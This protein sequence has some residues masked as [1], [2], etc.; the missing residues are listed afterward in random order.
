MRKILSTFI[1]ILT[2]GFFNNI[3]AQANCGAAVAIPLEV[4]GSC[5][6]M[7]FTNVDFTA[8]TTSTDAPA[9]TCGGFNTATE[10]MWYSFEVP[11]GVTELAFHAFNSPVPLPMVSPACAPGMAVYRGTCGNLTLIDC[12]N[13]DAGFMGISNGEIRWE[14]L[15]VTPGE[16][17]Y[18]RLWEKTNNETSIFFAAS[19]ITSLPEADCNNPPEL[20]TTGC[21]ILAPSGTIQAP[22]DCGW[23]TTDNVV[24]YSF[25]VLPTDPQPVVIEIE[26]GQCWGN[27][28]GGLLPSNP[29]IQF[30]V[31]SWNGVNCNGIGGG[32]TSD[33]A[34]TTTYYGCENGVGTVVYSNTLPP[35]QYVLAMDGHSLL[36]G[37]SLC[38]F[39][40]AASFLDEPPITGEL[41]VSLSKVNVGCG[42]LGSATITINSA[43]ST[44]PTINWSTSAT[45]TTVNNL[46]VGAYSVTVSDQAPCT[47]TIINFNIADQSNF[48]VAITTSGNP[49]TGPVTLL[50]NVMGANPANVDF[51]WSPGGQTTQSI[52]VNNGGTYTVTATYGTCVDDAS[53]TVTDGDFDFSVNY[54]PTFC[55]GSSG[56]AQF[57]LISGT[58]PFMYEWSTGAISPGIQITEPGNY[59]LTATDLNN[60]CSLTKC[61]NV[62]ELP[63]VDVSIVSKDIT[64]HNANDGEVTAI[65]SGGTSPYSYE[66]NGYIPGETMTNLGAGN[67]SV[68]VTDAAGCTGYATT[69]VNNPPQFT[70][71]ISPNQGICYGEQAEI[72]VIANG[73]VEPYTY[74]WSDEPTNNIDTRIVTPDT[75]T[76]YWVT[77]YDANNCM[78]PPQQTKVIVSLPR[79]ISVI[80]DNVLC[81]GVCSG[82]A[83]IEITGGVP[84]F[85]IS[86]TSSDDSDIS[87]S[88]TIPNRTDS[89]A[90]LC[91]G[92][93]AVSLTDKY[94][95]EGSAVFAIT[96]P[97]TMYISTLSGN[98]TCFGYADGFVQV[99]AT[100]G[101]PYTNEFGSFYEYHWSNGFSADSLAVGYGI[102]YVTVNDANGCSHVGM[103]FVDQP[104]DIYI[105]A[106]WNG[107]ICIGEPF[108]THVAATGGTGP[109][110]F[111]WYG[112][113]NSIWYGDGLNVSPEVTTTYQLVT[114]DSRG[115]SGPV[116]TVVVKVHLP[117]KI[118]EIS[119]SKDYICLGD[120]LTVEIEY[121]GGNGGPYT[122][123]SPQQGI[124]N[125][126]YTFSPDST[127]YYS[128]TVADDCGSPVD[129]DSIY[130][131]VHKAPRVAF[132]AD[133]TSSCPPGTFHF[134][135]TN[136]DLNNT[137]LWD[138]GDG[139]FSV[140]KNPVH[141]YDKTGNYTVSL[142]AWTEFGCKKTKTYNNLIFIHPKPRAEFTASPELV[143]I[144]NAEI[145]FDNFTEGG[146]SY[147]WDF[148]D[149]ETPDAW[150]EDKEPKKYTY[151]SVGEFD[152][153]LI[154][155]NQFE[156]TDSIHKKIKVHDEF[157]FYAPEAF[158]PNGDGI[159]DYFHLIGHGIDK[160]QFYMV[161]YDRFGI[162]VFETNIWD[163]E[164][165]YRMAWDGTHNG[166]VE[167]GDKILPN[168]MYRWY[169]SFVDFTGK[170]HEESGTVT[171]IR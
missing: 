114:I 48:A 80:V 169:A 61:F 166:S 171:I 25:E 60:G 163:E 37:N 21:N 111:I 93:Y 138:F 115:C 74:V 38:T 103:A 132:F 3:F 88:H 89:W 155:K 64:C 151:R 68:V 34:N 142:T 96:E 157:T 149:G 87:Y 150:S 49:C 57:N 140:E 47:D 168:G 125:T 94:E 59:C 104:D 162:K 136:E 123:T 146:T 95:C 161:I 81:H 91:A 84:P 85:N 29:E 58:G 107:Q 124:V 156:C 28:T 164:N 69:F 23:T 54:T 65:A 35:G 100:G 154:T 98:A 112:S 8:A 53:T 92:N 102:Y 5:G 118:N 101:V 133:K 90:S 36:S 67:Y 27:E 7:F 14:V 20:G 117:I 144:L 126:P 135:N 63:S 13:A 42:Q 167:N 33:P 127:G 97:D 116:Q 30:A 45:G 159:N 40:I 148:G 105:T 119:S 56:A 22:D 122:I 75:T 6:D 145:T 50:A 73:G 1:I 121:E 99:E 131:V 17:I 52:T 66:W 139:G 77:V 165:P 11:A 55:A 9:P 26:Y 72:S 137:Y 32:P 79:N 39:G 70:Y 44:N 110:E 130:V 109:Y 120:N 129:T 141:T 43:C 86:W 2:L 18:V 16:T 160:K 170:P 78:Y 62:I 51:V 108:S 128:F 134:T 143:S 12:F 153:T 4:Y 158:T 15:N 83:V 152:I 19:V 46:T 71:S 82:S 31:Y 106:P 76:T 24:F 147:F 41:S 113:D 10:D